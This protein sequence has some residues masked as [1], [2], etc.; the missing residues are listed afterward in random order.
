MIQK[1]SYEHGQQWYGCGLDVQDNSLSWGHTGAMDGTS[2]TVHHHKSGLSWALLFNS[3]SKDMDMD[4]LIKYALSMISDLPLWTGSNIFN[5]NIVKSEKQIVYVLV[6][7]QDIYNIMKT[8]EGYF[9]SHINM[10][11]YGGSLCV[12]VVWTKTLNKHLIFI[13]KNI[14]D[15]QHFVKTCNF[16]NTYVYL[17]ESYYFRNDIYYIVGLRDNSVNVIQ[18]IYVNLDV[19]E[20]LK[21]LETMKKLRYTLKHQSVVVSV[22]S[23]SVS[24]VYDKEESNTVSWLQL[25]M[26]NFVFELGKNSVKNLAPIYVNCFTVK[27]EPYVSA[28]WFPGQHKTYFQRHDVSI[29]GFLYELFET[30]KDNIYAEKMCGYYNEGVLNFLAVWSTDLSD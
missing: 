4:G 7:I 28:I 8:L 5:K 3:W 21:Q 9:I 26:E 15:I 10:I 11:D 30:A 14:K 24:S 6:P 17:F 27:D 18:E 12:N 19:Q 1:P 2:T 20:H 25:T 23:L 29:Y 16:C 22:D 13:D